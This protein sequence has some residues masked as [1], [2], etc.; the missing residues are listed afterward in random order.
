M[1]ITRLTTYRLPPRWMFL[2]IETDEGAE[3]YFAGGNTH[4]AP[5]SAEV[6]EGLTRPLLIGEN[7]LHREKL[8][9]GSCLPGQE[10]G[11]AS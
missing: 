10:G 11:R 3:G 4:F 5:L 1:K 7:P 2:K 6:I 8:W 9:P